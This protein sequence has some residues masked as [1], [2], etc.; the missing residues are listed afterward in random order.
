MSL[1]QRSRARRTPVGRPPSVI[2]DKTTISGLPG[3]LQ[4]SPKI[5]NSISPKAGRA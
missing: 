2:F 3:T 5:L 1:C 4:R